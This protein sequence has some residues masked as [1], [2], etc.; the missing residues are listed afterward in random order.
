MAYNNSNRY[1][2]IIEIQ[3]ITLEQQDRGVTKKWIYDNII[4]PRYFISR[5]CYFRYLA[6]NAK[7]DLKKLE[8][9]QRQQKSLFD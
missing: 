3:N 9:I 7:R 2:K 1:K 4:K 8:E 6:I 5:D